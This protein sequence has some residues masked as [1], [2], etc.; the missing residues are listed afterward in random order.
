MK[1]ATILLA[2]LSA[3]CATH[4][5]GGPDPYVG[6]GVAEVDGFICARNEVRQMG[7]TVVS[8]ENSA[9]LLAEKDFDH[10]AGTAEG[11][12]GFITVT[13]LKDDPEPGKDL[14]KVHAERVAVEERARRPGNTQPPGGWRDPAPGPQ[15][16]DTVWAGRKRRPSETRRRVEP[17]PAAVDAR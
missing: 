15:P 9:Y 14:L 5:P 13:V 3:G 1:R 6:S 7:Y 8:T 10:R 2:V 12:T 11:S 17:G 16:Y 4:R